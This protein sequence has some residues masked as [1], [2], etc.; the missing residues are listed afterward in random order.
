ESRELA[1]FSGVS[2]LYAS[3]DLTRAKNGEYLF[4]DAAGAQLTIAPVDTGGTSARYALWESA[5]SP[6]SGLIHSLL[7]A[8]NIR[9]IPGLDSIDAIEAY[10]SQQWNQS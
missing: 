2:T 6:K 5:N 3:I 4:F 9:G 1:V 7:L 10:I 8:K